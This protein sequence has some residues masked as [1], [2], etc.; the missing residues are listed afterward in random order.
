[1]KKN[2]HLVIFGNTH[3]AEMVCDYF[4][5]T[6]EYHVDAFTVDEKYI[7]SKELNNRPVVAFENILELYSPDR[8]DMFVAIGSSKLNLVREMVFNKVKEKGYYCPTY[9]H[10]TAY[11]APKVKLG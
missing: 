2:K 4:D 9:I 7:E 8:Y 11:V 10:P 5:S 6:S 3:F 1:M